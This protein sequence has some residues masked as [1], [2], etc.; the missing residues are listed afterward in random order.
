MQLH[1]PYSHLQVGAQESP[2]KSE[3]PHIRPVSG[4]TLPSAGGVDGQ[5]GIEQDVQL[6]EPCDPHV[7]WAPQEPQPGPLQVNPGLAHDSPPMGGKGGQ[8]VGGGQLGE[9]QLHAPY[10]HLQV[11]AQEPPPKS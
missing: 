5:A 6:Q 11:G 2:P 3:A 8:G 4:Q 10:S 7:H 9:M 1:K